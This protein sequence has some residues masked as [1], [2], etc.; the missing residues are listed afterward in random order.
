MFRAPSSE[1]EGSEIGWAHTAPTRVDVFE[2]AEDGLFARLPLSAFGPKATFRLEAVKL[3]G[4][5]A[6]GVWLRGY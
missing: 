1:L 2:A 6:A 5:I 3:H 4:A